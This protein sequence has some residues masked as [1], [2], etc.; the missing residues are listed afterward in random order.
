MK[1]DLSSVTLIREEKGGYSTKYRV[2]DG[3]G[4]EWVAKVGKEAQPETVAAIH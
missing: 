2:R 1:P 3:S 4:R